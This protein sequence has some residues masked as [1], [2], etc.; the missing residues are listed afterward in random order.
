MFL[1]SIHSYAVVVAVAVS[2]NI[3]CNHSACAHTRRHTHTHTPAR[4]PD[5][6]KGRTHIHR[7]KNAHKHTRSWYLN[8]L[9]S[10]AQPKEFRDQRVRLRFFF[11]VFRWCTHFHHPPLQSVALFHIPGQPACQVK[12]LSSGSWPKPLVAEPCARACVCVDCIPCVRTRAEC[13]HSARRTFFYGVGRIFFAP[14]G[15]GG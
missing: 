4:R 7:K 15:L 1:I 10:P 9:I 13:K 8:M 14:A 11:C 5:G 2:H 3:R 12:C 6:W